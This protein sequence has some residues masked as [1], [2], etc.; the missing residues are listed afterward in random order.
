MNYMTLAKVYN[1]H[2]GANLSHWDMMDLGMMEETV[3]TLAIEMM[4][5]R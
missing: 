5:D 2:T 1:H 3:L 4:G